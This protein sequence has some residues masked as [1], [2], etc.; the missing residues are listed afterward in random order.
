MLMMEFVIYLLKIMS[1][2]SEGFSNV[3]IS[4][5]LKTLILIIKYMFFFLFKKPT[6]F[7]SLKTQKF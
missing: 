5:L 2:E 4:V 7:F 1:K 6:T 3:D